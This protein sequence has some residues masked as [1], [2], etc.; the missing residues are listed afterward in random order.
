MRDSLERS[1]GEDYDVKAALCSKRRKKLEK[2]AVCVPVGPTDGRQKNYGSRKPI[3]SSPYP[4]GYYRCSSS[5]CCCARKQVEWSC[6]NPSMLIVTYTSDHN[7][8]WHANRANSN[9]NSGLPAKQSQLEATPILS[10]KS[11]N[12]SQEVVSTP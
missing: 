5:K 1:T 11:S 3:N 6:T 12:I 10:E 8:S 9:S 4:R 2:K 7:H